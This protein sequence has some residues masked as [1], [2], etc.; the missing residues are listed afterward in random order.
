MVTRS[1]SEGLR[2]IILICS[3]AYASGYYDRNRANSYRVSEGQSDRSAGHLVGNSS[4]AYA[5]GYSRLAHTAALFLR[6]RMPHFD[7]LSIGLR[8]RLLRNCEL[9]TITSTRLLKRP[10]FSAIVRFIRLM[11]ESSDNNRLRPN[12]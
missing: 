2:E 11:V 9:V 7:V 6:S 10:C 12:P 8:G 5:S 3:L 4:L 1:V